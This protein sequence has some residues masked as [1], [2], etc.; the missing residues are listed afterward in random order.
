MIQI[1]SKPITLMKAYTSANYKSKTV[2]TNSIFEYVEL[3]LKRQSS[4]K[5]TEPLFYWLQSR[6]FYN[7]SLCLPI[8]S[9][10]LTAY[11]SCMNAAKAL[12]ALHKINLVNI[13]HGV[14][15]ARSGTSPNIA[16]NKVIYLGSGVLNQLSKLF[17]EDVN[18][19]EYNVRDLLYNIPCIHRTFSLT[20]SDTELF[21][22]IS[23]ITF[24]QTSH[25]KAYIKFKINE[26]Y[27]NGNI[28]K[29]ISRRDFEKT[30]DSTPDEIF[31]RLKKRFDWDIHQPIGERMKK[32]TA[33][34]SLN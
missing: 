29:N 31:Y 12:L 13:S 34:H 20:Y 28:L 22:P 18:K 32:L 19:V 25:H 24:E 21:I 1:N 11:Y 33:Y 16:N 5:S 30:T 7:A 9:K 10:P 3:W 2:L 4:E 23:S 15:S 26:H 14:S 8:T 27:T 6:D 17:N